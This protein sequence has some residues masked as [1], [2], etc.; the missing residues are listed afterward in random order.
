MNNNPD[1]FDF[2]K[3]KNNDQLDEENQRLKGNEKA[4]KG[5]NDVNKKDANKN[6]DDKLAH[7]I[8]AGHENRLEEQLDNG[9]DRA[10]EAMIERIEYD[11]S[12]QKKEV[13]LKLEDKINMEM[14]RRWE[15]KIFN[16]YVTPQR[17]P[18][19]AFIQFTIGGDYSIQVYSNKKGNTYKVPSG[20]R[21][22]ADKTEVLSN[23]NT[24]ERVPFEKIITT[25]VRMSYSMINNQRMMVELWDYNSFFMNKIVGYTTVK[26]IELVNGSVNVSLEITKRSKPKARPQLQATI[27]FKIIFQEIWD[28]KIS[29]LNW[30]LENVLSNRQQKSGKTKPPSLQLSIEMEGRKPVDK[31]TLVKSE[32]ID[33]SASPQFSNFDGCM[34][35]RG[36]ASSFE[37]QNFIVKLIS[38]TTLFSKIISLKV[39]N[40]QGI[41]EFERVKSDFPMV[42]EITNEKYNVKFEGSMDIEEETKYKQSGENSTLY[43]TKKY[44]CINIMRVENIRPAETRGIVDSFIS[45]EYTGISQRTRTVK[46]N[47]NPSF[48]EVL[49][50]LCPIKEEYLQDIQKYTQKINEQFAKNNEVIFNLMIEGDDN[51]Y[52]NLGVSNFHLSEIKLSGNLVQKKYFADDL[53]REK[54][55]SSKVYT[56][57]LKLVSAFSLSNNTYVNF[58][59]WFLDDLPDTIDFGEKKSKKDLGDKIPVELSYALRNTKETDDF[60][61]K[62][63]RKIVDV[64]RQ[65]VNYS[66]K[67]RSFLEVYQMDQYKNFH[68][69]PYYLS[70]ISLPLKAF[71]QDD[72]ASNPCFHDYNLTS[73]DEVAHFVRCF[74]VYLESK[75]DVWSS[76]DYVIKIRKGSTEDHAILMACLMLGLKKTRKINYEELVTQKEKALLDKTIESPS[77]NEETTKGKTNKVSDANTIDDAETVVNDEKNTKSKKD[78]ETIKISK[79]KKA[80]NFQLTSVISEVFP[81][82]NR[83]FVCMGRL[84]FTK[85]RHLWIMSIGDDYKDITFWDPKMFYKFNLQGRVIDPIKLRNFVNMKYNDYNGIRANI[86]IKEDD[87]D[88]LDLSQS[89]I[90]QE[91]SDYEDKIL[92]YQNDSA[93]IK[94]EDDDVYKDNILNESDILVQ[95][96]EAA[97]N[98]KK[99]KNLKQALECQID[100]QMLL[101]TTDDGNKKKINFLE[102]EKKR[103]E[104]ELNSD[105]DR[106][107]LPVEEF[108]DRSGKTIQHT[109][110]PYET[111]DVS[112]IIL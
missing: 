108:K 22:F 110:L 34:I 53:K 1:Y 48:N 21:G 42:D 94:Y 37:T 25:E 83:I 74:P 82:E 57:K 71:T 13:R 39:V 109:S 11:M 105:N 24:L 9:N 70:A 95:N 27:D 61:E 80:T 88:D 45:V 79:D 85:Q 41:F 112:F 86:I 6:N 26:L 77:P 35:Y 102:E 18:L 19:D 12:N 40:L 4:Q 75:G 73:L 44:L 17:D 59:A 107:F 100:D 62:Y 104:E 31:N 36:T 76:P 15:V 2:N 52:D 54:K 43:S 10:A 92:P 20:S 7:D 33:G 106:F 103:M 32:I 89:I 30:K 63:K 91:K 81:Y 99:M 98:N 60:Y 93:I 51:T 90:K 64:F 68:L 16:I 58:E 72:I 14:I 38:H 96:Y 47:N 3:G 50:F 97:V 87:T 28:Y 66:Y 67:E 49:Y 56:G 65:Y 23:V 69:L 5:E 29:F 78:E 101:G 46:E 111:I 55:Y 8:N 84:K